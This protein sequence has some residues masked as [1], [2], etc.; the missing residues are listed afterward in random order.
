MYW[1]L[2]LGS[3]GCRA[4]ADRTSVFCAASALGRPSFA[5]GCT[6][7]GSCFCCSSGGVSAFVLSSEISEVRGAAFLVVP[8]CLVWFVLVCGLWFFGARRGLVIPVLLAWSW[9]VWCLLAGC[10]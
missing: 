5:Q 3:G 2:V 1:S 6:L 9:R 10:N 8:V 4:C 7:V